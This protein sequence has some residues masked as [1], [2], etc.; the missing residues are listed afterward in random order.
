MAVTKL[1]YI[2]IRLEY[3]VCVCVRSI[4]AFIV[5]VFLTTLQYPIYWWP[6][7]SDETSTDLAWQSQLTRLNSTVYRVAVR[8]PPFW[9]D[10]PALWF[11]QAEAQFEIAAVTRQRT[12]FNFVVSQLHQQHAPEVEDIVTTPLA[13]EPLKESWCAGCQPHANSSSRMRN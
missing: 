5:V 1:L 2:Q 13:L 7:T 12:K 6:P 4:Y 3:I 8:L 10:R 9:S 11:A